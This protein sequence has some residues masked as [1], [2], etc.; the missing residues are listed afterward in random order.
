M[1]NLKFI[2]FPVPTGDFLRTA[3]QELTVLYVGV[4][5]LTDQAEQA[6][7]DYH[8]ADSEYRGALRARGKPEGYLHAR[9]EALIS[10]S[11]QVLSIQAPFYVQIGALT[12]FLQEH[13]KSVT[14][15]PDIRRFRES[16]IDAQVKRHNLVCAHELLE[17]AIQA[18]SQLTQ[19]D[20]SLSYDLLRALDKDWEVMLPTCQ[21]WPELPFRATNAETRAV[22]DFLMSVLCLATTSRNT[23]HVSTDS[24]M[25]ATVVEVLRLL[26]EA[27]WKAEEDV[28]P[29]GAARS[30]IKVRKPR[31]RN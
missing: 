14:D 22:A 6:K 7:R 13:V 1:S 24:Q 17:R 12:K 15:L 21:E 4:S 16:W 10:A 8:Q 30:S 2:K 5:E 18:Y 3:L 28:Q 20:P 9:E 11:L 27:G 26:N 25:P 29:A 31:R 23:F 19:V